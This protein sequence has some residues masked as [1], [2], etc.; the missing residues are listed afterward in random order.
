MD[1]NADD[2]LYSVHKEDLAPLLVG[3]TIKSVDTLK[4]IVRLS[5][6]MTLVF[7]DGGDCCAWFEAQ[8]REGNLTENVITEVR[9]FDS[10]NKDYDY[11]FTIAVY[12]VNEEVMSVEVTGS[13]GSGYYGS[14]FDLNVYKPKN[15][16][17]WVK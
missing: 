12:A 14:S 3:K 17:E 1:Y 10:G 2:N 5:D 8:L 9:E 15:I 7:E 16:E 13:E 4:N 6:G 11:L